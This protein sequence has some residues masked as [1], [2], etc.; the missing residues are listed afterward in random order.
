MDIIK[1]LEDKIAL[2]IPAYEP[3]ER[4][5]NLLEQ[6]RKDYTGPI[7]LVNDGSAKEYDGFYEAGEKQGC[8]LLKHYRN[9]GK[10]RALKTAFNYCLNTYPNLIGCVTADSDG[11]HKPEDI[12]RCMKALSEKPNAL[13]LGCRNFDVEDVPFKSKFGNKLTHKVC[14]WLCGVDVSDTQTGLRGIPK[15]LMA[16]LLN[17]PGERFEFETRMLLETRDYCDIEEIE[18]ETVYD[19]KEN[20]QTHFDPFKD[21]LRIYKIFGEVFIKFLFSSL[22]SSVIDLVLFVLLCP[23]LKPLSAVYY[24]TAATVIARV[25]SATYNY[26][27]NYKFVFTSKANHGHSASRYFLL[28]LVQMLASALLVTVGVFLLPILP[29]GVIKVIVD[30]I[31]FFISFRIQRALVFA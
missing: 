23:I 11:Q 7:V 13:F 3:D 2:V 25:I 5:D 30:T 12:Y 14:K 24:V 6:L 19:S 18:I 4:L 26:L 20:H 10:G 17:T 22:S 9:M 31:L 1:T 21:S 8:V 15:E 16:K 29:E 27:I 28:A